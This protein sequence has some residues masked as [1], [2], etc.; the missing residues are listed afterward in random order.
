MP[1]SSPGRTR[2][3]LANSVSA[4]HGDELGLALARVAGEPQL[5]GAPAQPL[6]G[7]V[8][9]VAGR[10]AAMPDGRSSIPRGRIGDAC[11]LLLG[12]AVLT[13]LLVQLGVLQTART[14][15]C[16]HGVLLRDVS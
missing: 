13:Q 1:A 9:V 4:E 3:S 2:T 11:R 5:P 15:S 6:D 12:G 10:A 8:V 16:R 7:P 14:A